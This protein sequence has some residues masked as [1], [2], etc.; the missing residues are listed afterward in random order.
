MTSY[1]K[2]TGI[3]DNEFISL[4]KSSSSRLDLFKR[5]DMCASG[6]SYQIL[7]KKLISSNVDTSHFKAGGIGGKFNNSLDEILVENSSYK[8]M[9]SL[10][11]R[12]IEENIL[13]YKCSCGNNGEWNGK[14]L[15]LQLEHKNGI[16]N[17]HRRDN[18][19]FLCPNCHSQTETYAGKNK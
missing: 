17:D 8:N 4:V 3:P 7:K 19:E 6:T 14:K 11:K 5:L 2:I 16:S 1:S 18:L 9:T 15:T 13:P 12:L 10:K